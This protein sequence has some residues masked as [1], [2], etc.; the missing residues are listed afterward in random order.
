M[1][2]L[3]GAV[4]EYESPSKVTDQ[5]VPG[6]KPVS[7]NVTEGKPAKL[8]MIVPGPLMVTVVEELVIDVKVFEL[9]E[10]DHDEKT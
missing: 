10:E 6:G 9:F 1:I 4:A 7:V 5:P 3:A 8:A 2:M